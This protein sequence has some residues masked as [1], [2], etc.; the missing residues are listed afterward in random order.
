MFAQGTVTMLMLAF[1][2]EILVGG[3]YDQGGL[4]FY[5]SRRLG[6]RH[7]VAGKLLAISAIVWLTT[8]VPALVLYAE[9]GFLTD[10]LAYFRE[11]WRIL[12]GIVG[13][14]TV[15]AISLSLLLFALASWLNRTVPLVMAWSCVFVL[16]PALGEILRHTFDDRRWR[17]LMF[18]RD[19][20][21]LGNWCFGNI[22]E[23]DSPVVLWA[24]VVVFSVWLVCILAVIPR[25]RAV[26]VVS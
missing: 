6:R 21:L 8:M 7:Y 3:D 23:R 12:V 25:V 10:S 13:Y 26:K 22:S 2:G 1:V 5:L 9:Y 4:T 16:L 20:R 11:H 17:L 18:W 14:G 15:M 24:A 19:I